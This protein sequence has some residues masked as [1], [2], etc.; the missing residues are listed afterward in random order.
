MLQALT[1]LVCIPKYLYQCLLSLVYR[2][3]YVYSIYLY[4]LYPFV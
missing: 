3:T 2:F 1:D 4:I